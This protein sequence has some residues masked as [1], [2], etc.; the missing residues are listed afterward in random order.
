M[1]SRHIDGLVQ[2][3][4]NSIANGLELLQSCTK[5][6]I[7]FLIQI[8]LLIRRSVAMDIIGFKTSWKESGQLATYAMNRISC[9]E[10]RG[11]FRISIKFNMGRGLTIS[12]NEI[13][14][15]DVVRK[16]QPFGQ[17]ALCAMRLRLKN[18]IHM[19]LWDAMNALNFQK[20]MYVSPS[21][22]SYARDGETYI[23]CWKCYVWFV[24]CSCHRYIPY[25]V[26]LSVIKKGSKTTSME[27]G[28]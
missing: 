2:D 13:A 25:H 17:K 14:F 16:W 8:I 19:G 9:M 26:V 22:V 12:L 10:I 3:C 18:E 24:L 11:I 21:Q 15:E 7:Q 23:V 6:S 5:Q 28:R 4:S 20:T 1:R 27:C